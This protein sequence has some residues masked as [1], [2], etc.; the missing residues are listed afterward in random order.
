MALQIGDLVSQRYRIGSVLAQSEGET[1][2]RAQDKIS[3][4]DVLFKEFSAISSQGGA[5]DKAKAGR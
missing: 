3:G 4:T 1:L 5:P 2:Y